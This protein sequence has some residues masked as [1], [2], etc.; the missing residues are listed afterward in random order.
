M[1]NSFLI[2]ALLMVLVGCQ[3]QA[4]VVTDPLSD[5]QQVLGQVADTLYQGSGPD[6]TMAV[7]VS[8]PEN[9]WSLTVYEAAGTASPFYPSRT[10]HQ[11]SPDAD[12]PAGTYAFLIEDEPAADTATMLVTAGHK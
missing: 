3:S 6:F 8:S 11:L 12:N 7:L 9:G 2:A 5:R 4:F 10:F 1:K